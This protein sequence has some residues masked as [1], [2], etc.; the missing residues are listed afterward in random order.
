MVQIWLC[1][2][3]NQGVVRQMQAEPRTLWETIAMRGSYDG[4]CNMP[5]K[6]TAFQWVAW[7]G[8]RFEVTPRN[9]LVEITLTRAV[10]DSLLTPKAKR[11]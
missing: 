8:E 2:R 7:M 4:V 9:G 6:Q 3:G 10:Y 1:E 11:A 5:M